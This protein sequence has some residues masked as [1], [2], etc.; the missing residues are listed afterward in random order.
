MT[1][2][3][4]VDLALSAFCWTL[5]RS[6]L[7]IFSDLA[8]CFILYHFR[9]RF[10]RLKIVDYVLKIVDY[11]NYFLYTPQSVL[12]SMLSRKDVCELLSSCLKSR[13]GAIVCDDTIVASEALVT[14]CGPLFAELMA[15]RA[16]KVGVAVYLT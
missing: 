4:L 2:L 1:G 14:G 9:H 3:R 15:I 7:K 5:C 8:H 13:P 16:E 11:M 6:I 12:P 10:L